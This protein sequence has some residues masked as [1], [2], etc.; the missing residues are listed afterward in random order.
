MKILVTGATGYLGSNIA[1]LLIEKGHVVYATYRDNSSFEKINEYRTRINWIN[2][3]EEYDKVT[4]LTPDVLIHAA[5]AG[6]DFEKRNDWE[7]QL[8]NFYFSKKIIESAVN[9]GVRKIIVLGSQAEYGIRAFKVDEETPTVPVDAYGAVKLLLLN[10]LRTYCENNKIEWYWI[11]VFS[12]FGKNE[13]FTWLIPSVI[14]RL[15]KQE[16]VLLT[17]GEQ[18]YN[19]LYVDDFLDRFYRIV[20]INKDLSGIY[21]IC[22]DNTIKLK[23]LLEKIAELMD[24]SKE[25]LE[26]GTIPYRNSQN[27][28]I[29]GSCMK[30]RKLFEYNKPDSDLTIG[31]EKTILYK[32]K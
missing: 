2:V 30:F 9:S 3:S 18:E 20:E 23:C 7:F 12:V 4:E 1:G 28:M 26:F 16:K 6:L 10:F 5:W 27:M 13:N 17:K 24:V 22:N 29:A 19:Y 31:L 8:N 21:N 14:S 15:A 32:N 11:R 25:L